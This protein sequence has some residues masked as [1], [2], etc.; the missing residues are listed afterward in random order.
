M[1]Q[2]NDLF[3]DGAYQFYCKLLKHYSY[4]KHFYSKKKFDVNGLISYRD[5][6]LFGAI[7]ARDE[8]KGKTGSDLTRHEVKSAMIGNNFE[9]QYCRE[10]GLEKLEED[11]SVDHIFVSY[12]ADYSEIIV[13]L[14]PKE[15][16]AKKIEGWRRKVI[17]SYYRDDPKLRCRRSVTS[18]FVAKNGTVVMHIKNGEL[19]S[20]CKN[21]ASFLT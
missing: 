6:E 11:L 8:A 4:R 16:M 3:I 15:T 18:Q 12:S 10:S 20:S 7:L 2:E 19:L 14:V 17:D 21:V 9:Y 13:R 1:C 5:W